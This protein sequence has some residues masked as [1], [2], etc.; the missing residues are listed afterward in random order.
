MNPKTIRKRSVSAA[1]Q[2][3]FT[4]IELL[5]VIAII[6]LLVAILFPVFSRA[7]ENARRSSCQSNLKQLGLGVLQYAQDYDEKFPSGTV[8]YAACAVTGTGWAGQIF[9]Y[10]KTGGVYACP[11]DSASGATRVSYG[12][13]HAFVADH[14]SCAA[15]GQAPYYGT[16]GSV[17]LLNAPSLTVALFEV[18]GQPIDPSNPNENASLSTNGASYCFTGATYPC[19]SPKRLATGYLAGR[20]NSNS[21][22]D[23]SVGRHMDG[24]NYMMC[25][26][27]VK[28]YMGNQVS[29]GASPGVYNSGLVKYLPDPNLGQDETLAGWTPTAAGSGKMGSFAVTFSAY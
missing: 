4:L 19:P 11:N 27:H 10:V 22:F 12:I 17:A 24:A 7:R 28:W 23:S 21:L 25:D 18:S 16:Y 6:C 13:N 1:N 29:T 26:G 3:G 20:G 15:S 8:K 14:R 9:P 2:S 5:V